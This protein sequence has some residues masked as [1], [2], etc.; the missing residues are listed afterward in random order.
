MQHDT[1]RSNACE[2]LENA[3]STLDSHSRGLM[4]RFLA[5]QS[6]AEIAAAL[7][8]SEGAVADKIRGLVDQLRAR[9]G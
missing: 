3:L 8:A 2:R 4:E 6:A 5:G 1:P 7:Q 9:M